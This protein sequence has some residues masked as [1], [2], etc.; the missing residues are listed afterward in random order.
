MSALP[1]ALVLLWGVTLIV[2]GI[3]YEIEQTQ[4]NYGN[5][6]T[7][8]VRRIMTVDDILADNPNEFSYVPADTRTP[9]QLEVKL[10]LVKGGDRLY[11]SFT[12]KS[13]Q[14]Y[15]T[16]ELVVYIY[17]RENAI[18]D[19]QWVHLDWVGPGEK[20]RVDQGIGN[21]HN[22]KQWAELKQVKLAW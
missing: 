13:S 20:I 2:A 16:A 12:N 18:V 9:H 7:I 15:K 10:F 6:V 8:N 4:S 5:S 3:G 21:W 19:K 17:D 22:I 14:M 1:K 11:G